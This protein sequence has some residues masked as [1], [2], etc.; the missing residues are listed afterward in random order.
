[1]CSSKPAFCQCQG[2]MSDTTPPWVTI[3]FREVKQAVVSP[4]LTSSAC[5]PLHFIHLTP[6][7]AIT[8]SSSHCCLKQ[9][10]HKRLLTWSEDIKRRHTDVFLQQL[11]GVVGSLLHGNGTCLL[12]SP[13]DWE[14]LQLPMLSVLAVTKPSLNTL[15][16]HCT[17]KVL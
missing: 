14:G 4:C 7:E 6:I 5:P 11:H 12:P 2:L 3:S 8:K 9:M 17:D 10:L 1:M 13:V 16:I 15:W